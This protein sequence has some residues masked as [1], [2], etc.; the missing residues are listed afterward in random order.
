VSTP[1]GSGAYGATPVKAQYTVNRTPLLEPT[2]VVTTM[3]PVVAGKGTVAAMLV[4][5]QEL[6]VIVA[7]PRVADPVVPKL[8]PLIVTAVLTGPVVGVML[9]ITGAAPPPPPPPPPP[10][11]QGLTGMNSALTLPLFTSVVVWLAE[12]AHPSPARYVVLT[13][14]IVA[15]DGEEL[16]VVKNSGLHVGT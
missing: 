14:M 7:P 13:P 6:V 12:I 1:Y 15:E 5:V 9:V 2:V 3:L 16:V 11:G 8:L 10:G 4:L